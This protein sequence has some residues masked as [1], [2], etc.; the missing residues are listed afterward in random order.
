M[1]LSSRRPASAAASFIRVMSLSLSSPGVRS[2]EIEQQ[3]FRLCGAFDLDTW[4]IA[5]GEAV[6]FLHEIAIETDLAARH[7]QP[8]MPAGPEIESEAFPLTQQAGV[9]IDILM[10][11]D[12]ALAPVA[13]G[14]QPPCAALLLVGESALL[15]TR[16]Q[17]VALGQNPDLQE[18]DGLGLGRVELGMADA[19]AGRHALHLTGTNQSL[20]AGRVLMREP[21]LEHIGDD[22]HVAVAVRREAGPRNHPVLVDHPQGPEAHMAGIEIM[23]EGEAVP[24]VEPAGAGG[25]AILSRAK[26]HHRCSPLG[27]P[28]PAVLGGERGAAAVMAREI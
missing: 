1:T 2:G 3:D 10:H 11:R 9:E 28:P 8:G 4:D 27:R 22:L 15:I 18:M 14:D 21:T 16:R 26:R 7:L 23:A 20:G 5:D 13:R 24:A 17:A 6:A 19:G 25:A 12:A